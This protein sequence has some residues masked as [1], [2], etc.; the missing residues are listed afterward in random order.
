M[1]KKQ[2]INFLG[3]TPKKDYRRMSEGFEKNYDFCHSD[4]IRDWMIPRSRRGKQ[5]N[6]PL[7]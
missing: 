2:K 4:D 7:F 3:N 1:I 6:K 5:E